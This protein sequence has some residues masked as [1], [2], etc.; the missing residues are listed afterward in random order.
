[1]ISTKKVTSAGRI[2]SDTRF[3][4]S[5]RSIEKRI[6]AGT[7]KD[8]RRLPE[9]EVF[10]FVRLRFQELCEPA[11]GRLKSVRSNNFFMTKG[12]NPDPDESGEGLTCLPDGQLCYG[13]SFSRF[14][15]FGVSYRDSKWSKQR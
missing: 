9:K 5:L 14:S 10:L 11:T 7:G 2:R 12:C 15:G 3:S 6:A 8:L 13:I 4:G 1:L